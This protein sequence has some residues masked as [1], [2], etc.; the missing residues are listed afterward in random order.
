MGERRKGSHGEKETW[1]ERSL[2]SPQN[3]FN[4]LRGCTG[5]EDFLV[6]IDLEGGGEGRIPE[7]LVFERT[8][9]DQWGLMTGGFGV[10][11][12]QR[13]FILG[14]SSPSRSIRMTPFLATRVNGLGEPL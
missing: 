9:F 11:E 1:L 5:L 3:P 2:K 13:T 12:Y 7:A 8:K 6:A 4:A 14:L 10:L